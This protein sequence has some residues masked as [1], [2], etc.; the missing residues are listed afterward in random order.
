MNACACLLVFLVFG[1]GCCDDVI[2]NTNVGPIMGI[3]KTISLDGKTKPI[4]LFYGV[5]FG[6][7]TS[8]SNRFQKPVPKA[9]FIDTFHANH[10][11]ADACFQCGKTDSFKKYYHGNYSED[12]LTLDIYAPHDF[13]GKHVLPVMVWIYGGGFVEGA[14]GAYSAEGLS[15]FGN[16]IVV[17]V[18]YRLAMFG[19]LRSSDGKFIG[20][21]GLWDQHL[22]IKWVHDNIVAFNGNPDDITIFGES[23]G[24]VSVLYQAIY[25]G[26]QGLFRRVIAQSGSPLAYWAF[27]E[28]NA[29][30]Y[31][32][33]T[34]CALH[35][36]DSVNCMKSVSPQD[37]QI[38][39]SF[40][41]NYTLAFQPTVDGDFLRGT[42]ADI[43]LGNST[44]FSKERAFFS[45][46]DIVIG[47]N[48]YDGFIF[49]LANVDQVQALY[50][51]PF[52]MTRE[53]FDNMVSFYIRTIVK[54]TSKTEEALIRSLIDFTY[55]DW[56]KPNDMDLLRD[57]MINVASDAGMFAPSMA[58]ARSHAHYNDGRT[59]VYMFSAKPSTNL[60]DVP[61]WID[62]KFSVTLSI[63]LCVLHVDAFGR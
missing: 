44:S 45:S 30:R 1:H 29:D 23:A 14:T 52:V 34:P 12:C 59:F 42:P 57:N 17:M 4:S 49:P 22:G 58:L 35:P 5:P 39:M 15:V 24:S 25:P 46:L 53:L 61:M 63:V 55:T 13:T 18:N 10:Y 16:V 3:K 33:I 7:A 31:I 38:D 2:V 20:N 19:F 47:F 37:L 9:P 60:V 27:Q 11:P 51:D 26:N 41:L 32:K 40:V 6:E 54:P 36:L 56:T 8:G 62:G 50:D 28:P 21:Q 48:T 43:I